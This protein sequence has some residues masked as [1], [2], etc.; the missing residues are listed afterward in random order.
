MPLADSVVASGFEVACGDYAVRLQPISG[1]L[2]G[3]QVN[4]RVA[5]ATGT[6]LGIGTRLQ[7]G[8]AVDCILRVLRDCAAA[9]SRALYEAVSVHR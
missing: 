8:D 4:L 7:R 9:E 6:R 3:W 5:P 1:G 2:W